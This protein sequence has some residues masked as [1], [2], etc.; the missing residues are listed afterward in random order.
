MPSAETRL[1]GEPGQRQHR[2][3][4]ADPRGEESWSGTPRRGESCA[5]ASLRHRGT[6]LRDVPDFA[7][8]PALPALP[9]SAPLQ[10]SQAALPAGSP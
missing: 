3:R 5:P 8:T 7:R 1:T 6:A 10:D 4:G 2:D 9:S